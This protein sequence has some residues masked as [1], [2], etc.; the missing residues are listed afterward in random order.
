[1]GG[2]PQR[3]EPVDH[4]VLLANPAS[5][6]LFQRGWLAYCLSLKQFDQEIALQFYNM[7]RDGYATVK[8]IHTKFTEEV[9][10][11][12]TGLPTNGERWMEDMDARTAKEQF[13]VHGD[14]Q[15][16]ENKKQG[17]LRLS[18]PL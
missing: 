7:L 1:M 15:L 4:R 3:L 18:L 10:A 17:T 16:E 5:C 6:N 11:K 2:E 13:S 9:V 12:V 14:P 8:G